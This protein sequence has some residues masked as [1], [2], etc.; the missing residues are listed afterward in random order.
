MRIETGLFLFLC[1]LHKS[2]GLAER[3]VRACHFM[4][5]RQKVVIVLRNCRNEPSGGNLPLSDR[6]SLSGL[7]LARLRVANYG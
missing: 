1:N 5:G 3:F 2:P 4:L 6:D 7:G